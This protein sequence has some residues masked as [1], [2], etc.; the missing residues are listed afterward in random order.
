MKEYVLYLHMNNR[1]LFPRSMDI[2]KETT[3]VKHKE[4]M[5][6]QQ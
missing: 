1:I 6:Q 4:E 3:H 2:E 5:K